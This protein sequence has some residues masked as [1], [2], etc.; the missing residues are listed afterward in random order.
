MRPSTAA[1]GTRSTDGV[2]PVASGG[3]GGTTAGEAR[4]NLDV[5]GLEDANR[6]TGFN[7]FEGDTEVAAL[8]V[9]GPLQAF[10]Q[11]VDGSDDPAQ[12]NAGAQVTG[13]LTLDGAA[14]L[15]DAPSDGKYYVRKDGA[16]VEIVP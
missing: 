2:L 12:L 10:G 16:W 15:T 8:D 5:P 6:L 13:T 4:T 7:A 1:S 3:T 9:L 11:I 14:V